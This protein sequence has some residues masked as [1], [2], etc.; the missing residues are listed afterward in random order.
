MKIKKQK[1]KKNCVIKQTLKFKYYKNF[2]KVT[3]LETEIKDFE[4]N[5]VEFIRNTKLISI[6]TYTY[7]RNKGLIC[8]KEE[9]K[10]NNVIK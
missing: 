2:L 4:K 10:C 1:T 5:K 6:E 9:I 3:Q 8:R 7:G